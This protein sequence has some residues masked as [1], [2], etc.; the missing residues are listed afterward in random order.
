MAV[1]AQKPEESTLRA[2]RIGVAIIGALILVLAVV[3]GKAVWSALNGGSFGFDGLIYIVC[4][5][6]SVAGF[7]PLVLQVRKPPTG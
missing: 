3:T 4:L 7:V 2:R 5:V 1:P 6:F